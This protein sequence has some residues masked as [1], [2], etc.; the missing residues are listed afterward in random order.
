LLAGYLLLWGWL[1]IAPIDRQDWLLENLLAVTLVA[2]LV[3]T[4]RWFQFSNLS[5]VL[6]ALFMALH[7][8]GAHYTYAKVPAGFWLQEVFGL[9]RNPFDRIVHFSYGCLLV[10]PIR[11]LLMRLAGVRGFWSYYLPISAVLAQSGFFEVVEGVVAAIVSPELGT[12][13]LGTQGDEWDAQ[14]DMLAA[15]TGALLMTG[16]SVMLPNGS[17]LEVNSDRASVAPVRK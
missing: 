4:Y 1:A 9:T 17:F 2:I 10:L 7:A 11:E 15:F 3:L 16:A 6:I 13:Y 14:K 5:Y 8:I 12:A